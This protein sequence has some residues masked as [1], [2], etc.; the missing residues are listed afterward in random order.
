MCSWC[1]PSAVGTGS[2]QFDPSGALSSTTTP[3]IAISFG[4]GAAAQVIE[5]S[6]GPDIASG[7]SG[8]EGSTSFASDTTVFTLA[9]DGLTQGTGSG[10][11]VRSDGDV[12]V[13]YDNGEALS[14][15]HLALARFAHEAALAPVGDGWGMTANSGPPQLGTPQ[16]PGRGMVVVESISAW[17]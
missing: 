4:G 11:D 9:A 8:Y 14:I 10:I 5:L 17:P 16:S 3:P 7:A 1:R 12:L 2:L 13:Y 6:F 15:G